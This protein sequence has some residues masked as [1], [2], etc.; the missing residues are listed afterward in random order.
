M[1]KAMLLALLAAMSI[2]SAAM[3]LTPGNRA[4]FVS[5]L[6]AG[7]VFIVPFVNID[8]PQSTCEYYVDWEGPL[9]PLGGSEP[10]RI[11]EQKTLLNTSCRANAMTNFA[12]IVNSVTGQCRGYDFQGIPANVILMLATSQGSPTLAGIEQWDGAIL[13]QSVVFQG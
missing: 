3:A 5:G 13:V 4:A 2:P 10:C 12:T 7:R 1:K 11:R 6:P 9:G 8:G